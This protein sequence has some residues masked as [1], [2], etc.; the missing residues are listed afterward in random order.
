MILLAFSF[1]N[2]F[3][4]QF[5]AWMQEQSQISWPCHPI[6]KIVRLVVPGGAGDGK[7]DPDRDKISNLPW[8]ITRVWPGS[9]GSWVYPSGQPGRYINRFFDKFK[10]VQSR[11]NNYG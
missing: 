4:T 8:R 3:L 7:K 1:F 5:W 11:F 9:S 2:H 6:K 10:L